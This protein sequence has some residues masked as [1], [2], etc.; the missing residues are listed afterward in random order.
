[1]GVCLEEDGQEPAVRPFFR[2]PVNAPKPP[3][4]RAEGPSRGNDED[5]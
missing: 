4:V 3:H 5:L 2:S 1:M